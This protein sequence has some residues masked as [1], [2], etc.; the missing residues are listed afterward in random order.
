[1]RFFWVLFFALMPS[2]LFAQIAGAVHTS[3]TVEVMP[4]QSAPKK[5]E[6]KKQTVAPEDE[7]G[8]TP[9]QQ[10]IAR[11][12]QRLNLKNNPMMVQN[13]YLTMQAMQ[14]AIDKKQ[15]ESLEQL[16][17][18]KEAQEKLKQQFEKQ[19]PVRFTSFSNSSDDMS[20]IIEEKPEE[21]MLAIMSNLSF[22]NPADLS[23][24]D[25]ISMVDRLKKQFEITTGL[26][27]EEYYQATEEQVEKDKAIEGERL[28][29]NAV[30]FIR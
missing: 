2:A 25:R 1:M 6:E 13:Y 4:K 5:I 26:T 28:P 15:A 18:D 16:K 20:K 27:V 22:L 17:D 9:M 7:K 14:K 30:F 24:E 23:V 21:A 19:T 10:E 8:F 12:V 11:Q 29:S 3:A